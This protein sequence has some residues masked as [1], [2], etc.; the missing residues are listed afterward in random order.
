MAGINPTGTGESLDSDVTARSRRY[1]TARYP[2][3]VGGQ[4]DTETGNVRRPTYQ[5]SSGTNTATPTPTPTAIESIRTVEAPPQEDN[6][7]YIKSLEQNQRVEYLPEVAGIKHSEFDPVDHAVRDM[8]AR[9]DQKI[10]SRV[11]CT[12]LY[13]KREIDRDL[14]RADL[15]F[16]EKN[17][18]AVTVR[19]YHVWAIPAVKIMRKRPALRAVIK[20]V[21]IA[22]AEEIG[23]Q[24]GLR[25]K[26][27]YFGKLVRLIGEPA[28]FVIGLFA[29]TRDT[30]ILYGEVQ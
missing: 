7:E 24:V 21:A 11:I 9:N 27:N 16:T 20:A 13:R 5:E 19:G 6:S 28:C 23:Y 22:R 17:L 30:S 14:Y 15:D 18:S 2:G 1:N 10:F 4:I 25:S 8:V 26:P 12:E 3:F 29:D